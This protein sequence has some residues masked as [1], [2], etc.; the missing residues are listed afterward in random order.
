ME[1]LG[2]TRRILP[3]SRGDLDHQPRAPDVRRGPRERRA[4]YEVLDAIRRIVRA[5]RLASARI[6]HEAGVSGAQLFLLHHLAD[7]PAGSVNELAA[8]V[9]AD[10]SSVSV[11]VRRLVDRGLISRR[12]SGHDA[13][14]VELSLSP[15]GRAL[16]RRAPP[17]PQQ[18][19]LDALRRLSA[20]RQRRLAALL[21]EFVDQLGASRE[22]AELLY[23]DG[24]GEAGSGRGRGKA[25]AP[26]GRGR[27]PARA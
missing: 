17:A 20:A 7:G 19:M 24:V 22:R 14:R 26:A 27:R 16:V 4:V 5:I 25:G 13:R 10:Q 3:N 11:L 23:A 21:G 6:E 15:R 12:R 9:H 1:L 2:M 18:R 8:R